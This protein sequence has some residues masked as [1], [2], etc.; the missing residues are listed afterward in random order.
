MMFEALHG[1]TK[2]LV[3]DMIDG[4]YLLNFGNNSY[5]LFKWFHSSEI[6]AMNGYII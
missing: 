6:L 2:A 4:F 3:V 5:D 1:T